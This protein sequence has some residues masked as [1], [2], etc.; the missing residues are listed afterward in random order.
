MT[1]SKKF[2]VHFF[3]S[4][5]KRTK[6]SDPKRCF[7]PLRKIARNNPKVVFRYHGKNVN[8]FWLFLRNFPFTP[9]PARRFG[10]LTPH[11]LLQRVCLLIS[12]GLSK[13]SEGFAWS[14]TLA[15]IRR[16]EKINRQTRCKKLCG[17]GLPKRR[18]GVGVSGKLR[19][20]NQNAFTFFP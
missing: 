1:F 3:V 19:R 13:Q 10:R 5:K 17:A 16:P 15:F 9:T 12:A 20:N 7:Y 11:S 14:E 2:N 6:E 18:A 4:T 8:A